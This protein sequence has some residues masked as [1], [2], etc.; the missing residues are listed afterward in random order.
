MTFG[1]PAGGKS[2]LLVDLACCIATGTNW[3][4][5]KVRQGPV[6][7]IAGEGHAGLARRFAAW[8]KARGV[9]ITAETPL[10]KS[11]RAVM[12]LDPDAAAGVQAEV[13][14]M[15][16]QSGQ[17][18]V[19]IIIDT[20]ARNFG[21]GDENKQADAGKFIE[22]LDKHLRRVY[23]CNVMIVHHSGHEMDRARGSSSLKAAMDQEIS[24]KNVGGKIEV[25]WTKMKDAEMPKEKRFKISQIGL[26]RFD[27]N[28]EEIIGAYLELDGNPLDMQV[29]KRG[30][31]GG[32]KK[33]DP[34]TAMDIVKEMHPKW[35][36]SV[37]IEKKFDV[38]A[39]SVTRILAAM[40][41]AGW[42]TGGQGKAGYVLTARA[43]DAYSMTGELVER[44]HNGDT[45]DA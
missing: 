40:R 19:L 43:I 21:D 5:H 13:D 44:D 15:I 16:Q 32:G 24:V 1:A 14:R 7:Y 35:Q 23:K 39:R 28:G 30:A 26:G 4:N 18:P 22:H 31:N 6:F 25:K 2:F 20:L 11:S 9:A 17:P 8:S 3:F 37:S 34:I 29:G 10:Y 42:V 33:G 38:P 27:E 12:L 41:D 45:K 36:G